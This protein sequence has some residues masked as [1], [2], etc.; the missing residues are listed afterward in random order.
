MRLPGSMKH[1]VINLM[2][3]LQNGALLSLQRSHEIR[4][5][6]HHLSS[7]A[8]P[9]LAAGADFQARA[10][11]MCNTHGWIAADELWSI[12]Q[13]IMFMQD[14]YKFTAPVYWN[15]QDSDFTL[16]PFGELYLF[17]NTTNVICVLVDDH[18]AAIEIRRTADA[19]NL[20][21]V[22][23]PQHLQNA[24]TRVV[25]RL[26]DIAPHRLSTSSEH[27]EH[28]PHLCGWRLVQRWV[29]LFDLADD[30]QPESF[31]GVADRFHD[32]ITMTM[33]CALE[34]W[35]TYNAPPPLAHLAALLRKKF[36]VFLAR[37][38]SQQNPIPQKEL[39]AAWP[40]RLLPLSSTLPTP[41]LSAEEVAANRV[42]TRLEHMLT[43]SGWM[44]TDEM[45][46]SLDVARIIQPSTLFCAPAVWN[47]T[48]RALE[49][50]NGLIP[51]YGTYNHV[52]WMVIHNNHWLQ[53]ERY[54]RGSDSVFIASVPIS[55]R[56]IYVPLIQLLL[57]HLGL[58]HQNIAIDFVDQTMPRDLCGYYLLANVFYRLGLQT[59]P[60]LDVRDHFLAQGPHAH[61][62]ARVRRE[63][64]NTW[65]RA[66]GLPDFAVFAANIR[67]WFLLRVKSN[68]FPDTYYAA[69]TV[70]DM[71]VDASASLVAANAS[72]P[73][74]GAGSSAPV[75]GIDPVW[76]ND[77]WGR[78]TPRPAQCKSAIGWFCRWHSLVIL[79]VLFAPSVSSLSRLWRPCF[80]GFFLLGSAFSSRACTMDFE[81]LR[82][83][84]SRR[85]TTCVPDRPGLRLI[86]CSRWAHALAP[87][88]MW[89]TCRCYR[90][91]LCPLLCHGSR[92]PQ[93]VWFCDLSWH[94]PAFVSGGLSLFVQVSF[95]CTL[96]Y[97]GEGPFGNPSDCMTLFSANLGSFRTNGSWKTWS[98]DVCCLQETRIGRANIRST[99]NAV[100]ALGQRMVTSE[101]LPVKWHK[102]GSITPCGGTAIIGPD[103]V[104][105]PFEACHDQAGL[106]LSL[107]R[108]QRFSAA[109]VQVSPSC[110]ILVV[111]LY[112]CTGP[113][114]TLHY[115]L[116]MT[117]CWQMCFPLL[118]NL[119]RSQ[120]WSQGTSRQILQVMNRLPIVLPSMGGLIPLQ[121]SITQGTAIGL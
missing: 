85:E 21:F 90:D 3:P 20:N 55:Q 16:S 116:R 41:P 95:D 31:A 61:L 50:P 64:R 47:L 109:W 67:D 49:F 111:S 46:F 1:R 76:V 29:Q 115:M 83:C 82:K 2:V 107:M 71:H 26:L 75:K 17:N 110:K 70:Q 11:Y 121:R 15:Q 68:R 96:G 89:Y 43:Y 81:V 30:F 92:Q 45:D 106:F 52:I 7:G 4:A 60:P 78:K 34:D 33:E 97:P 73:S 18:W 77:P 108:T 14:S 58:D 117:S 99:Q 10:E 8:T 36:L 104:I 22:Q 6:G 80:T 25:A 51:E 23:L 53:F 40:V 120:L 62:I 38:E 54:R 101:P 103:S 37:R 114:K 113:P 98:A 84:L 119:G 9:T 112:A 5:G 88:R 57:R 27:E 39:V 24:A 42:A 118:L 94:L 91:D 93:F 19:A 65:I 35:R 105:Q 12:T 69:G 87:V 56:C 79:F 48:T 59:P 44:A 86:L 72:T 13:N 28:L 74:H 32:T 66:E 100:M 102:S 63:A